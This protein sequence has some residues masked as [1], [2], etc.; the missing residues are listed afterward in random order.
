MQMTINSYETQYDNKYE[1][2]QRNLLIKQRAVLVNQI[3]NTYLYCHVARACILVLYQ[4][5][6]EDFRFQ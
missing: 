3:T 5:Q 6:N 4:E 1:D 2:V